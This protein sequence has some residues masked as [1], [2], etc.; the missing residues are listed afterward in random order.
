MADDDFTQRD[1]GATIRALYRQ[2]DKN[3]AF[4]GLAAVDAADV[5]AQSHSNFA[6]IRVYHLVL[7]VYRS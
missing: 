4:A 2:R 1:L 7:S 3:G 6:I 5:V